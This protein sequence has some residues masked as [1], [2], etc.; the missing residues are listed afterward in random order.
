MTKIAKTTKIKGF[1][2]DKAHPNMVETQ[3]DQSKMYAHILDRVLSPAYSEVIHD[4]KLVPLI[5]PRVTSKSMEE[6]QDWQMTVE[7][8]IAP[9]YTLGEYT[10]SLKKIKE[11]NKNRQKALDILSAL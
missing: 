4:H 2:P 10:K 7:V 6:G 5:E 8:A 9:E 1:Y 3:T 11:T